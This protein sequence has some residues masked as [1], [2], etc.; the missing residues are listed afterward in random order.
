MTQ[1]SMFKFH[2]YINSEGEEVF[3]RQLDQILMW[4]TW[5]VQQKSSKRHELQFYH[6]YVRT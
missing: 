5:R 1:T 6:N 3:N 4:R 2:H